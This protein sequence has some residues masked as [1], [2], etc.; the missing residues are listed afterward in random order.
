VKSLS[1]EVHRLSHDLHPAKL[2]QLGL[3]AAVRGFCKECALAHEIAIEFTDHDIPRTVSP[4]VALSLYR[5]AQEALHNVVKHSGRNSGTALKIA[6]PAAAEIG[7]GAD[8]SVQT[9]TR[10]RFGGYG[11]GTGTAF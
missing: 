5:I 6:S 7:A 1:S 8:I 3:V 9:N 10:Y 4:D 2:D 11:G